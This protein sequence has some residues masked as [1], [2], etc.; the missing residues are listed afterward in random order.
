VAIAAATLT[1]AGCSRPAPN[2]A[3]RITGE[4]TDA[5]PVTEPTT[6]TSTTAAPT[7]TLYYGPGG[8]GSSASGA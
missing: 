2:D 3:V 8:A 1:F 4:R 5:V 7:T 6:T